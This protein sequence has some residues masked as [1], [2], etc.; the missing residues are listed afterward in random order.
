MWQPNLHAARLVTGRQVE[1]RYRIFAEPGFLNHIA[2]P[3]L[4]VAVGVRNARLKTI[5]GHRDCRCA[6]HES[7]GQI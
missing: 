2:V 7:I 1:N 5:G 3:N 4:K 6:G